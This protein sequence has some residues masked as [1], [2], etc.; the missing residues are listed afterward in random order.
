MVRLARVL[1]VVEFVGGLVLLGVGGWLAWPPAGFLL[2]G[3]V[4]IWF[5]SEGTKRGPS[6]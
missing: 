1:N 5:T 3:A 2:P 6:L 4:L